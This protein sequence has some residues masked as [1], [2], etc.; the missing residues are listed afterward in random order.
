M[1]NGGKRM[2]VTKSQAR[3]LVKWAKSDTNP[4]RQR[5]TKYGRYAYYTNSFLAIRWDLEDLNVP[6][7]SWIGLAVNCDVLDD[8]NTKFDL[9]TDHNMA[10]WCKLA[11]RRAH[12]D[13]M[14]TDRW[15][16]QDRSSRY[17]ARLEELFVYPD[18]TYK[19]KSVS[20]DPQ[21]LTEFLS[22]FAASSGPLPVEMR[23]SS[24]EK[25]E[26][27]AWIFRASIEDR[28]TGLLMPMK[29]HYVDDIKN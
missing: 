24:S 14:D 3:Q 26:T 23:P 21:F 22:F 9:D 28:V 18:V 25:P 1:I 5:I 29:K 20:F 4:A 7:G 10:D 15:N 2:L 27:E 12:W 13:L 17:A 8:E 11:P 6:D 16:Q 19:V